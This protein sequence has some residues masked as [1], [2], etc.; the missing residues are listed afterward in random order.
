MSYPVLTRE[1]RYVR[2]VVDVSSPPEHYG[3]EPVIYRYYPK[4]PV[5][6]LLK[7]ELTNDSLW[8]GRCIAMSM[9]R[10]MEIYPDDESL[11]DVLA[12]LIVDELEYE[13]I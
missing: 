12:G 5:S 6:D 1:R 8:K 7:Y 3:R 13:P 11:Q 9:L 2:R 10:K 4:I